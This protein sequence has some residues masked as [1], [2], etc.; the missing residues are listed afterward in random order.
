MAAAVILASA[1]SASAVEPKAV[2]LEPERVIE[3]AYSTI[4]TGKESQLFEEYFPQVMP[5][6]SEYGGRF[7]A[8]FTV[9]SGTVDGV[10]PQTVA[11]FEWPSVEAFLAIG[12]DPR[13]EPLLP[14]RNSALSYINEA[15]FFRIA[16]RTELELDRDA[17]YRL[18]AASDGDNTPEGIVLEP[19]S[20]DGAFSQDR[21]VIAATAGRDADVGGEGD[22]VIRLNP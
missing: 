17:T 22:F 12:A 2:I 3:V 6:V 5:I 16:E 4:T 8:S 20:G 18:F 10:A 15:N 19:V 13:L 21:L 11:L 1:S 14:I 7:L 9:M